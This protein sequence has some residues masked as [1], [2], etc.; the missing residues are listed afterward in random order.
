MSAFNDKLRIKIMVI[1]VMMVVYSK[2][3]TLLGS[4]SSFTPTTIQ[5]S[6]NY[7][8][9]ITNSRNLVAN[10]YYQIVF[11]S[12]YDFSSETD[13]NTVKTC[14]PGINM[15]STTGITSCTLNKSNNILTVLLGATTTST[16]ITFTVQAIINPLYANVSNSIAITSYDTSAAEIDTSTAGTFSV[17]ATVG[18]LEVTMTSQ[19]YTVG[20]T[21]TLTFSLTLTNNIGFDGLIHVLLPKW[22]P[23]S[24]SPVS[25]YP[26]GFF[27]CN[28]ITNATLVLCNSTTNYNGDTT[29]DYIVISGSF[30][31][32][33]TLIEFSME[34]FLNPPSTQP[35]TSIRVYTTTNDS[36]QI[37]DEDASTSLTMTVAASLPS[38]NV[39]VSL[40]DSEINAFA[41]YTFGITV[42]NPLPSG[43]QI[44]ITFP[45]EITPA[46]TTVSATGT[47]KIS[48]FITTDYD[49]STKV[50]TLSGI[51][52]S[53]S[54][55]VD[56]NETISIQILNIT[57]PSSTATTGTFSITT[58]R[59]V[60][61]QIETVTSGITVT[62]TPGDILNFTVTPDNTEIRENT[63]YRFE[64]ITENIILSGSSLIITFPSEITVRSDTPTSCISVSTEMNSTTAT[65]GVSG[66]VL[67][68][69]SGF[70]NDVTAGNS[71]T[72]TATSVATNA[73]TTAT[74]SYFQAQFDDSSSNTIDQYDGTDVTLTFVTQ[75]LQGFT[76]SPQ[77][78]YTG[79]ETTYN[80]TLTAAT[81]EV[82]LQN[83][84]INI[85]F[86]SSIEIGN[87]TSSASSCLRISGF[88][89]DISCSFNDTNSL[90]INNGFNSSSYSG[91]SLVFTISGIR[92][93]RSTATTLSFKTYIY[94]SSG[95]GQYSF[96][97]GAT[98]SVSTVSNLTDISISR[99]DTTNAVTNTYTFTITLVNVIQDGDYIEVVFPSEISVG[100]VVNQCA[101]ITNLESSLT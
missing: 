21:E 30:T 16:T 98:I 58:Y 10:E 79:V 74:T 99:S 1:F 8:F 81:D 85:Q 25:I 50:L 11:P 33:A 90:I 14:V 43:S 19:T 27:N 68:I 95:N 72:F 67:T 71:I 70:P 93:P 76:V 18:S 42:T 13:T 53:A 64:F 15:D 46:S 23:E 47:G 3:A 26:D 12:S 48:S 32:G 97:T 20:A 66:N 45:T 22:N 100:S 40:S 56:A 61:Y 29:Q 49:S 36:S 6:A 86:P 96:E 78:D 60:N 84:Y 41:S 55:Y 94:D 54:N 2:A 89:D 69:S 91:G 92:N 82:I 51:I 83:S 34:N 9:N 101:G 62:A 37:L 38:S 31:D 65:C 87:T 5:T 35:L 52:T 57:N 77:S 75:S 73:N 63:I 17:T 44:L 80:F 24:T 28:P 88:P 4:V 39:A 7:T 59:G